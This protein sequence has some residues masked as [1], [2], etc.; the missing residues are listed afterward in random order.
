MNDNF[1]A[2]KN[3]L[4]AMLLNNGVILDVMRILSSDD[5]LDATNRKIYDQI[6]YL[7]GKNIKADSNTVWQ[8]LKKEVDLSYFLDLEQVGTSAT[9]KFN[10]DKTRDESLRRKYYVLSGKLQQ[11]CNSDGDFKD[12]SQV[13]GEMSGLLEKTV[14]RGARSLPEVLTNVI[15]KIETIVTGKLY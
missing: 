11:L 15:T 6:L 1:N 12:I 9:W 3:V 4:G 13:I 8:T 5:F 7:N 10:C 14:K 2:E